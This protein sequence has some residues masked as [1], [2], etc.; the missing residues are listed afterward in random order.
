MKPSST[1]LVL[2]SYAAKPGMKIM[3][4]PT[5]ELRRMG[6]TH[7]PTAKTLTLAWRLGLFLL[8]EI[9]L[10]TRWLTAA[11]PDLAGRPF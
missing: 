2:L 1:T 4:F 6:G 8:R 5:R 11:D 10:G 9:F 3:E 7:K